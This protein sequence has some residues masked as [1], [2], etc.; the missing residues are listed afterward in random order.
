MKYEFRVRNHIASKGAATFDTDPEYMVFFIDADNA[1]E[2]WGL[3]NHL[4]GGDW[5]SVEMVDAFKGK[6]AFIH[7]VPGGRRGK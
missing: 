4:H 1:D 6:A 2:A 7:N 3:F 5:E